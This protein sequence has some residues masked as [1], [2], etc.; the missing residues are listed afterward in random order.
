MAGYMTFKD[1]ALESPITKQLSQRIYDSLLNDELY[2]ELDPYLRG[3]APT[4][5]TQYN[6]AYAVRILREWDRKNGSQVIANSDMTD[7]AMWNMMQRV[8]RY[9]FHM[10]RGVVMGLLEKKPAKSEAQPS[11]EAA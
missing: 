3:T 10:E 2:A 5:S 8:L 7:K 11:Q 4:G 1:A 6:H 9:H